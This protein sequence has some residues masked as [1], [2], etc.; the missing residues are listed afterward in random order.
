MTNGIAYRRWLLASN[1]ELCKLLDE[2]IGEEYKHDAS[3]LSKLNKYADDKTVLKRIN[4]IKL[5][6]KK[7]FAAY[8]EKSTGQV[9]DPNSI[10]DCQVKRMHEYKRQHLNAPE[11]RRSVPVSE[12]EP[13]TPTSSPRPISSAQR[14]PP[15]Y[16]MAKQM[17]PDDLQ[18]GRPDQQ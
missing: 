1:P 11:H 7:N 12:G 18:A 15:G 14:L 3:N 10:F 5:N 8:L 9:I 13:P 16:Y 6:N 4:E 17:I 2:T